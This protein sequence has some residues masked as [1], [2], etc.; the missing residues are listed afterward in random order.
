MK[1]SLKISVQLECLIVASIKWKTNLDSSQVALTRIKVPI[2]HAN[3]TSV[4]PVIL[5]QT[6]NDGKVIHHT[7]ILLVQADLHNYLTTAEAVFSSIVTSLL[8]VTPEGNS[9]TYL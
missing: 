3:P 6:E 4:C 9:V 7:R 8:A 5:E 1:K 2:L